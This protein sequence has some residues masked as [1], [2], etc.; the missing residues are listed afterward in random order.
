MKCILCK[1]EVKKYEYGLCIDC[2][3]NLIVTNTLFN[4]GIISKLVDYE[5]N[6]V[7]KFLI[8]ILSVLLIANILLILYAAQGVD[9]YFVLI[10]GISVIINIILGI[11]TFNYFANLPKIIIKTRRKILS[12]GIITYPSIFSIM[13]ETKKIV[14]EYNGDIK[15]ASEHELKILAKKHNL[16]DVNIIKDYV[17]YYNCVDKIMKI[18]SENIVYAEE[19]LEQYYEL[20]EEL[21]WFT[22][23]LIKYD[24]YDAISQRYKNDC[25]VNI[26]K[27]YIVDE[28][29]V[30]KYFND[31]KIDEKIIK[32]LPYGNIKFI[33]KLSVPFNESIIIDGYIKIKLYENNIKI[34]DGILKGIIQEKVIE[35]EKKVSCSNKIKDRKYKIIENRLRGF[36]NKDKYEILIKVN[37][38][39]IGDLKNL[40]IELEPI[41]LWGCIM[42]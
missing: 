22:S 6:I 19:E 16:N 26:P 2:F 35:K 12:G 30:N 13:E 31:I 36:N 3:T 14:N 42:K 11:I 23:Y 32:K 28:I 4:K 27:N 1:N 15:D 37:K 34:G 33:L 8:C 24:I 7:K 20:N 17:T 9:D 41:Q 38:E 25:I 29:E 40:I 18:K 21:N 10:I 39:K 5:V